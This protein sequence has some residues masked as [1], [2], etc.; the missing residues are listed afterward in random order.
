M[1]ELLHRS[2]GEPTRD[3][4]TAPTHP[5]GDR[6]ATRTTGT[7]PPKEM[8]PIERYLTTPWPRRAKVAT[9]A[10][11]VLAVGGA[12]GTVVQ[13]LDDDVDVTPYETRIDDLTIARDTALA[14]VDRLESELAGVNGELATATTELATARIAGE[15]LTTELA[16][17]EDR[18]AML[19]GD[20]I[21]LQA[22]NT[23]VGD[24]VL[25]L[26]ADNAAVTAERD[27]LA[28]MFPMTLD[29][30]LVGVDIAGAYDV[31]WTPAYN[32]GLADIA[33]PGVARVRIVQ[34][35]EGWLAIDVPGVVNAGLHRSDGSLV[36][37]VDS[38]TAVPAVNG[39]ARTARV[40][41]TVYATEGTVT[42]DGTTTLTELGMSVAV[43]TPATATTPAGVALYG[44][45]LTP[46]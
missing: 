8:P 34:T 1:L 11:A 10:L 30:S 17:A 6:I 41:I 15:Q 5:T 4:A 9:A 14:D 3:G 28:A 21:D 13:L 18:I 22:A 25:D 32:S 42:D 31:D 2:V 36:A 43:S 23:M 12:V 44:A 46:R 7:G 40:A 27:A 33:L 20:V 37:V 19:T 39:V 26:R 35:P 29:A 24:Q 16:A 38:T 45:E